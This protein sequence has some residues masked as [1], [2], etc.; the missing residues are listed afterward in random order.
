MLVST[1]GTISPLM[2][3]DGCKL[4]KIGEDR[5]EGEA[6]GEWVGLLSLRGEGTKTVVALLDE[7]AETEPE[8]LRTAGLEDLLSLVIE[9]GFEVKVRHTY[10][11]WRLLKEQAD[12]SA[13]EV[14]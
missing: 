11:H 1:T 5:L 4:T 6:T 2:G 10:G 12:L 14:R 7:L 9:R 8:T 13:G 3:E